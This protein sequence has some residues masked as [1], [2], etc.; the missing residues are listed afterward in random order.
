MARAAVKIPAGRARETPPVLSFCGIPLL[1]TSMAKAVAWLIDEG[2]PGAA[3]SGAAQHVACVNPDCLNIAWCD[4]QYRKSLLGAARVLPD[5][6]GS[7][8]RAYSGGVC[9]TKHRRAAGRSS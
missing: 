5:G 8:I 3:Q 4:A 7:H 1:S 2:G 6:I 9:R